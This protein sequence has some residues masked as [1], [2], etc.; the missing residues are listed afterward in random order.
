MG[1]GKLTQRNT[2]ASLARNQKEIADPVQEIPAGLKQP[3][4]QRLGKDGLIVVP[5]KVN[6]RAGCPPDN[7]NEIYTDLWRCYTVFCNSFQF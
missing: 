6:A 2:L 7:V 5:G 1:T 3:C 4:G